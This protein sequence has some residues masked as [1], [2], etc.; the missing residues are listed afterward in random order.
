MIKMTRGY[1]ESYK[2]KINIDGTDH[3]SMDIGIFLHN[4]ALA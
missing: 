3:G 2:E 1:Y 4:R